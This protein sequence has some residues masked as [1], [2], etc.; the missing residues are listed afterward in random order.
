MVFPPLFCVESR[1]SGI[2]L[3]LDPAATPCADERTGFPDKASRQG[4]IMDAWFAALV[5]FG[6]RV[7]KNE[8]GMFDEIDG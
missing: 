3:R 4:A 6:C 1:G 5:C 8:R 2:C 7:L